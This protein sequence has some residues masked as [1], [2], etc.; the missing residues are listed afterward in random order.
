MRGAL[1]QEAS[2]S[3]AADFVSRGAGGRQGSVPVCVPGKGI[4]SEG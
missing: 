4:R 3:L 2:L 1:D